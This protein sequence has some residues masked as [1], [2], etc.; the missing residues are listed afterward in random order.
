LLLETGMG[1]RSALI[2]AVAAGLLILTGVAAIWGVKALR[3]TDGLSVEDIEALNSFRAKVVEAANCLPQSTDCHAEIEAAA[4][5]AASIDHA[6]WD[7][8]AADYFT[9]FFYGHSVLLV[10][11]QCD[12]DELSNK[13]LGVSA[14]SAD[15]KQ[16]PFGRYYEFK[17]DGRRIGD[18]CYFPINIPRTE[19]SRIAMNL[20]LLNKQQVVWGM[21]RIFNAHPD[22]AEPSKAG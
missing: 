12:D 17:S 1:V 4:A 13:I 8:H 21:N 7:Y 6:V 22:F 3:A 5:T 2:T 9:G 14:W 18:K 19:I 10:K 20:T 16:T 11:E 15:Q